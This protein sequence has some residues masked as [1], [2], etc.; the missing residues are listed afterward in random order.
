MSGFN[1]HQIVRPLINVVNPDISLTIRH[2]IG[3]TTDDDGT[4]IPQYAA[5]VTV[6]GQVQSLTSRDLRQIDALNIQ[7][8]NLA[9]YFNGVVDGVVRVSQHGGDLIEFPDPLPSN[10][11]LAGT[12]WLTTNVLEQWPTGWVK[13]SVTLQVS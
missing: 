13:V 3:Y 1:L 5:P 11:E 9:I 12:V 7:P 4:Q 8:S 2:S 6:L 10:P